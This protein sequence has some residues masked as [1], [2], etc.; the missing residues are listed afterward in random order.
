MKITKIPLSGIRNYRTEYLNSLP[1]FQEL[2]LEIMIREGDCYLLQLN[3]EEMGYAIVNTRGVLIEFYVRK[4]YLRYS[5]AFFTKLLNDLSISELYCKSFDALLLK[6]CMLHALPYT[7]IGV[8][9]RGYAEASIPLDPEVRLE[10]AGLSSKT[11]LLGQDDSIK[12]LFE[13]E[14]QLLE[15]IQNE[16]VFLAFHKDAFIGCGMVLRTHPDWDFCDLGVWVEPSCRG[17]SRG[18][19]ILLYLRAFALQNALRPSCGCAIENRASQKMI[20]K[21]GFVS[22]HAMLC[23]RTG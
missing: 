1:E 2:F 3:G 4:N 16:H 15:F 18:S 5:Q 10:K 9:Y 12:E 11:F 22:R 8:L 14:Q 19:Q 23:F 6:N 7:V 17:K 13:T 20:E 21:S